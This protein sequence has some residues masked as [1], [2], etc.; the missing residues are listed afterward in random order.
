MALESIDVTDYGPVEGVENAREA[1]G[2]ATLN[3]TGRHPFRVRVVDDGEPGSGEDSISVTVGADGAAEAADEVVYAL[4]GAIT[5]GDVQ[6]LE[7]N[8]P[9]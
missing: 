7:L 5:A 2:L 6:L 3:G 9:I 1:R 4:D 8:L